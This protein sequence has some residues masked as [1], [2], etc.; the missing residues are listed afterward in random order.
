M[1]NIKFRYPNLTAGY[2]G[3]KIGNATLNSDYFANLFTDGYTPDKYIIFPQ[4]V[5]REDFFSEVVALE[6]KYFLE[7][8][9]IFRSKLSQ[10][11]KEILLEFSK[12]KSSSR[13]LINIMNIAL[14]YGLFKE[15]EEI[16]I[17]EINNR[18][19]TSDLI[20]IILQIEIAKFRLNNNDNPNLQLTN[21]ENM[22]EMVLSGTALTERVQIV[23][24]TFLIVMTYRYGAKLNYEKYAQPMYNRIIY[25]LDNLN[26]NT[27]G[28]KIRESVAY[29]GIA[30][31]RE[32][33]KELK[34]EYLAR[35]QRIARGIKPGNTLEE[36]IFKENLYTCLQTFSKW[37][38]HLN[39]FDLAEKNLIEMTLIDPNDSTAF[40]ELGFLLFN[41][42]RIAEAA[43][44]FKQAAKLGP[45][46]VGMHTY[47]YAKCLQE[48]GQDNE[49]M[50]TLYKAAELDKNAVSPW[51]DI[52]ELYTSMNKQDKAKSVAQSILANSDYMEQLEED[53][54]SML[55]TLLKI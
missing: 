9:K 19:D 28:S 4:R 43:D 30:M 2:I 32:I 1:N 53:E 12:G 7:S 25:I 51:L 55:I 34:I 40:G 23:I 44:A 54:I 17:N 18:L 15:I 39:Q 33:S 22:A 21:L 52:V 3:I 42:E 20:E 5:L 14:R 35:A 37:N 27:F 45:P 46:A 48:M 49:A 16:N 29:R 38:M 31:V 6:G 41:Q 10:N 47:F 8:F 50:K 36:I 26:D 11:L 13:A 24:L